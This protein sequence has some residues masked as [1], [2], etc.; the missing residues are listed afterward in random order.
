MGRPE[1]S[2]IGAQ[3]PV[4]TSAARKRLLKNQLKSVSRSFYLTV[5][6]LPKS[7]RE[8]IALAYLLARSA[9]TIADTRLLPWE[10]RLRHL[11]TFREQI[12][13]PAASRALYEIE[14][15]VTN[16]QSNLNERALLESLL[17]LFSLLEGSP[18]PDRA[19]VRSV[20]VTLTQGME[21]DLTSF[22]PE[23]SGR[24]EALQNA[25]ELDNYIY[26]VAGCVG[27]FWT[28][29]SMAHVHSLKTWD[30]QR[31]ARLGVRF[32]KALQ[33]TNVVRDLPRDIRNGR[34]YLPRAE[35][36]SVGLVPEELLVPQTAPRARPVLVEW[37][38]A[39]MGHYAA[40]EEYLLAVPRS[41][42]RLRLAV[43]WP[44]LIGLGTLGELARNQDWLDPD[45]PA[46]V[47]RGWVYRTMAKSIPL[48]SIDHA[49]RSWIGK[50]RNQV[51]KAL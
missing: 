35:L 39:A 48:V 3:L 16:V 44:I 32:G 12:Q 40:S 11:L 5:R 19:R 51:A 37:I 41:C 22:P 36:S 6:V 45:R 25:A 2:E 29:V 33:L 17:E 42:V 43:L 34:C 24:V 28:A 30:E 46:K 50:S 31:M 15:A 14:A 4:I 21:I 26:H 23:D 13:G 10:E 49:L 20:V 9:D 38:N 47:S 7:L 18:E 8:P 27:E 1:T